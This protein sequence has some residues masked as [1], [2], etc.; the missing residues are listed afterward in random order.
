MIAVHPDL[1]TMPPASGKVTRALISVFDKTGVIELGQ[2]LSAAGVEILSSGGTAKKLQ[3]A[4]IDVIPVDT[5]TGADEVLGGRVKT[6][7]PKIHAGILADRRLEDHLAELTKHGYGPIDLVVCSL[8]PFEE[9]LAKGSPYHVM[10]ENIDIGGPT[11]L[12]A[13]AKNADGG[14]T[15]LIDPSDY[16]AVCESLAKDGCIPLADRRTYAAKVFRSVA[17][18]DVAIADWISG[19][20]APEGE[21]PSTLPAQLT[22]FTQQAT[23]RYGENPHQK[24]ALYISNIEEGGVSSGKVLTGKALSY[25]NYLDMD[26]AYRAAY[27]LGQFGCSVVKH[28][29]TCGLA[30]ASTQA[31]AF[32]LALAGDPVSAFGSILGF[33]HPLEADTVRAIIEKK[34]FVECIAAPGFTAEAQELLA[35]KKNLRLF[36]VPAGNPD[37]THHTHRIGGGMLVQETD[38]GLNDPT[39]WECVTERKPAEG[40]LEELAFAMR[41]VSSLKSN[42]ITLTK[43]KSLLGAGAGQMSRLDAAEQAIKKAGEGSKGSYMGSDAFFP[44]DDCVRLAHAAGVV[45]VV[46]PG[47]SKRDQDSIDACNELGMIMLFTGRRHFRH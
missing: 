24:A 35:K 7:H 25:N 5:Y 32:L 34:L 28:T 41:A 47:G 16:P 12:R 4:G 21:E 30:E 1:S 29:N 9:A 38:E 2:A 27:K 37:P 10:V 43:N 18:Y 20:T 46:Q 6:L 8:Y 15:T 14:V 3:E 19:A 33:N 26:A 36:E 22:G 42:A 31:E 11:M 39:A 44:F 45:G 17:R 23:L 13:A 40:E